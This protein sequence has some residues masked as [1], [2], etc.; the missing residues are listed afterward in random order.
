MVTLVSEKVGVFFLV[1]ILNIF[2]S[3]LLYLHR[4]LEWMVLFLHE[5]LGS[6]G[7]DARNT[8]YEILK[9]IKA[10]NV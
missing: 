1:C 7:V 3:M 5:R 2:S 9:E 10:F 4:S 6:S 8:A